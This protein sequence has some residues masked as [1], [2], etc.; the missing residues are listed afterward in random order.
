MA[1]RFTLADIRARTYKPR[2]AWWTVIL[3]DP[4]ASR[5]V[6]LAARFPWITP[7]RLTLMATVL[8]AGSVACFAMQDY[9]WL[10]AG[11][12]LFHLSFVID[13]MDGK[14]ARLMGNGSVFG[15][16]LD[17]V[18][19]RLRVAACTIALMGGQY[20]RTHNLTYLLLA[21][22]VIFLDMFRY[23]NAQQMGKVKTLMRVKL[24][25]ARGDVNAGTSF[26]EDLVREHPLGEAPID[27]DDDGTVVDVNGEFRSR[28]SAF[29]RFRNFLIRKRIRAHIISGIEF[30]M[31][32]FIVG[33]I[34]FQIIPVTIAS[35]ALL[36]G[37]ETLL[38]FK[39]WMSTRSF[40]RQLAGVSTIPAQ[41]SPSHSEPSSTSS[42]TLVS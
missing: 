11:A 2:D 17:F 31:F 36:L 16:W 7:N 35:G 5:L 3:V 37:F 15:T 39:L 38:V 22:A 24:A 28:F 23:L 40:G 18:F 1:E 33:P 14:I 10:V 25:E 32:V 34:A 4:L 26:V 30:E 12:L 21:S 19:D 41:R 6:L 42:A 13:C 9:P 8:G 27:A 20:L 29:V